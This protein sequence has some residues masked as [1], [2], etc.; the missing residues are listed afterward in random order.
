MPAGRVTIA[1]FGRARGLAHPV[2][3]TIAVLFGLA[4]GVWALWCVVVAFTGGTLPLLG[5]ETDGGLV[6][7]VLCIV[8]GTPPVVAIAS[9]VAVA[10]L[11]PLN[12]L[13]DRRQR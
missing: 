13:I 1:R 4:V 5:I 2:T 3:E 11:V 10:V 6:T 12:K 9:G 7:G 8:L